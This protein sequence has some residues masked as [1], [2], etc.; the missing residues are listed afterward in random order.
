VVA[1]A[2]DDAAQRAD[3]GE[4]AAPGDGD[5]VL[6]GDQVVGRVEMDPACRLAAP[7]RDPGV[8]GVGAAQR[9]LVLAE[10]TVRM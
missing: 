5:V 2:Q 6:L 3:V 1:A 10:W 8:A 4:V 9:D 7:H